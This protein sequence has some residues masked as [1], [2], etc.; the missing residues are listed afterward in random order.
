MYFPSGEIW[1]AAISG[2][3]KKS[4]RSRSGGRPAAAGAGAAGAATA[5][6]ATPTATG[7]AS[8]NVRTSRVLRRATIVSGFMPTDLA[9]FGRVVVPTLTVREEG[10][11]GSRNQG[12]PAQVGP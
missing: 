12:E 4:S 10:R 8:A 1:A 9:C 7:R 3:P 6:K 11:S 2:L 5:A